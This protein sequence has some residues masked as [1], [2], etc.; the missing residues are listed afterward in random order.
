MKS[1]KIPLILSRTTLHLCLTWHQCK[2]LPGNVIIFNQLENH[3]YWSF[4]PEKMLLN[5]LYWEIEC[6]CLQLRSLVL[7]AKT[8]NLD[9][10]TLQHKKTIVCLYLKIN[11]LVRSL[12]CKSNASKW[13]FFF[14]EHA[15]LVKCRANIQKWLHTLVRIFNSQTLLHMKSTI[16]SKNAG[17][18]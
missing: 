18:R 17:S 7:L 16:S 9:N 4:L 13:D 11:T 5:S 10:V 15:G 3:W 12:Q 1:L 2:T 6:L 14:Y 8:S